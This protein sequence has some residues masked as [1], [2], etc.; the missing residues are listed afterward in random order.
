MTERQEPR[1]SLTLN[2]ETR[3]A[4]PGSFIALPG[5]ITHYELGGPEDGR[6]VVLVH[7]FSVPLSIWDPTFEALAGAGFRVLR[8][9]LFGRGY[10]DRPPV[11]NNVDLFDGQLYALLDALEITSPVSVV[12]VSMGGIIGASFTDRHLER[13]DRLTL[14]DPAGFPLNWGLS[15]R[16]LA[17]P[18]LGEVMMS[19]LGARMLVSGLPDDLFWPEGYPQYV[20]QFYPQLAYRG[21]RRSILSTLRGM[22]LDDHKAV[23]RRVGAQGRPILLIWGEH[24]RTV[25]FEHH[26]AA[27]KA[28]PQAEFHAIRE[29]GHI[30]H[31]ERPEVVNPLLI[32]FLR[33]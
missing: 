8:Y 6:P 21:F 12:G 5:G 23:Y 9:D 13:V 31:Y 28:M 7:G 18:V 27:L 29:A 22:P 4:L 16:L 3:A 20:E 33:R 17:L 2:E 15:V 32:A 24:D 11:E 1:E 30:P 25:P 10:S 26:Q 14:I 19:L